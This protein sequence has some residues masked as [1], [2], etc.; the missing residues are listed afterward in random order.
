MTRYNRNTFLPI[1]TSAFLPASYQDCFLLIS[2]KNTK[3]NFLLNYQEV[4]DFFQIFD[5]NDY[6]NSSPNVTNVMFLESLSLIAC[7]S[8][9]RI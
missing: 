9:G 1:M 7:L 4:S 2:I 6:R 3:S 5:D 8:M